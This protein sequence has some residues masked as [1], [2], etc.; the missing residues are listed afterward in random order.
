MKNMFCKIGSSF[1]LTAMLFFFCQDIVFAGTTGKISG[2]VKDAE[3][4]EVLPGVNIVIKG[5]NFGAA[6]DLSGNYF[7]VNI[8]PGNYSLSASM[9]G[10]EILTKT[11]VMVSVDHTT[12]IDF[13]LN[14]TT[15]EGQEVTIVAEKEIVPMDVSAS[16]VVATTEEIVQVPIV[17]DISDFINMQVGIENDLIRG[18]GLDQT[19]FMM[20]GL[21]MVDNRS[22]KPMMNVNLGEI[23]EINIIQG[24]F[25]AEYG[26]VRSGLINVVTK[27]GSTTG[28]H[29]AVDFRISPAHLKHGGAS[30]FDHNNF[31]LRPY[32]DPAVCWVG[33]EKGSWDNYT[34]NQYYTFEG[35]NKVSEGLLADND[36]SND[37]TPEECR[38]LFLWQTRAEGSGKLGQEEGEYGNKPDWS[39]DGSFGGM[40]P[41]IG[42]KLGNMTFFASHRTNWEM[43]ALP[44]NR[45]YYKEQNS[46]LKLI[47]QL[48]QSMKLKVEAMYG[49]VHTLSQGGSFQNNNYF[50]SGHQILETGTP[51]TSLSSGE[52]HLYYP[53]DLCPFDVFQSMQGL[54]FDHILS[55]RTFYNIRISHVRLKN[56]CN[57]ADRMRDTTTVRYFGNTPVDE[58]PYGFWYADGKLTMANGQI[59][60]VPSAYARDWS[61]VNTV[62]AKFDLTSQIDNYN[63]IKTGVEIVYDDLNS[64]YGVVRVDCPSDDRW[65][66]W[67]HY[68]V[69]GGAYIQDKLEFEGMIANFGLRLDYNNPNTDWYTLDR[70]SD[71]FKKQYTYPSDTFKKLAPVEKAEGHLSSALG[72]AYLIQF[73]KIQN[74]ILIMDIFIQCP[75]PVQ[76]IRFNIPQRVDLII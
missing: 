12:Q 11:D 30:L 44:S 13:N 52:G 56:F 57:F 55:P 41:L 73:L 71:Y 75:L 47:S 3:T 20:D 53:S 39:V 19:G 61:E 62:N 16:Q 18:G 45:D 69:R 4:G 64:K 59:Y 31:Y 15:L 23:K 43:F 46:H 40:V 35:W 65:S 38:D 63:Q 14:S 28:Y 36:P 70:Y 33:T 49:E 37:R 50:T 2:S 74:S 29:G 21:M 51:V 32:L 7:I 17:R 68:P 8:A 60:T 22:N 76:C 54:S 26:N 1:I 9:I 48:S 27:E 72:W 6:T 5:T 10:Y 66:I 42:K 25:N 67:H 58:Q 24:G 34:K